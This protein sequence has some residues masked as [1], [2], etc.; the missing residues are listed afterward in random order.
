MGH[1]GYWVDGGWGLN[2]PGHL[3]K[4]LLGYRGWALRLPDLVMSLR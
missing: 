3:R 1:H 4:R 2:S